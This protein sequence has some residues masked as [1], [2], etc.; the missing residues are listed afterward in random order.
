MPESINPN[1]EIRRLLDVMPASG[2]M[3]SKII[4]NSAQTTVIECIGSLLK[5]ENR[6]IS[7]NFSLWEQLPQ[8]QRDLLILRTVGW[9]KSSRWLKPEL[10]QIGAV[11]GLI[12]TLVEFAQGDAVGVVIAAGLGAISTTQIWRNSRGLQVELEADSL[13]L[14][15]AQ[16][17]GYSKKE[18]AQHLMN[19]IKTTAPLEGRA[20]LT[21]NELIRSQNLSAIADLSTIDIPQNLRSK[22]LDPPAR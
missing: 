22:A 20:S 17:R 2:R 4:S 7:I 13:A 18:A 16:R 12:G 14:K 9:L 11:A 8:P 5:L 10:Y 3:N 21:F 6:P 19:A 1:T 15:V